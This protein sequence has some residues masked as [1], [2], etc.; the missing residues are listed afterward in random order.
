MKTCPLKG[1]YK[2]G[3]PVWTVA[4]QKTSESRI[5]R[6]FRI[7][8]TVQ[9]SFVKVIYIVFSKLADISII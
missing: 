3:F 7:L 8:N 1:I 5:I 2:L 9:I 6:D 4:K